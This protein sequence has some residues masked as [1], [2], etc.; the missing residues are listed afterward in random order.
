MKPGPGFCLEFGHL[1]SCWRPARS[2]FYSHSLSWKMTLEATLCILL[3]RRPSAELHDKMH[4]DSFTFVFTNKGGGGVCFNRAKH[5]HFAGSNVIKQC[6]LLSVNY[7]HLS[8]SMEVE[9]MF[10]LCTAHSWFRCSPCW[11]EAETGQG[12][13]F[14]DEIRGSLAFREPYKLRAAPSPC[15]DITCSFEFQITGAIDLHD[16]S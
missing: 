13:S 8:S 16:L 14:D 15:L 9:C 10:S 4:I 1:C 2:A 3:P 11:C 5:L 6:F 12:N 7:W